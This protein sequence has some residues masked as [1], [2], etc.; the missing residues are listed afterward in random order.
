MKVKIPKYTIFFSLLFLVSA[1]KLTLINKGAYTFDDEMRYLTSG[2]I[3]KQSAQ[4]NFQKSIELIF[5][6]QGRPGDAIV[7]I[8]PNILQYVTSVIFE[9]RQFES[10]NSF[11]LFI[12]NNIVFTLILIIHYRFSLLFLKNKSLSVFSVFLLAALVASYI[13]LRHADPY[14]LSLLI[15]YYIF[16]KVLSKK[17]FNI[18][19]LKDFFYYGVIAF[20]GYCCYPGYIMLFLAIPLSYILVNLNYSNYILIIKQLTSFTIGSLF[21]LLF[22]ELLAQSVNKSYIEESIV[23]SKTILQGS[24]EESFTF[25]FKYLIEVE[26]VT[27]VFVII[28]LGLFTIQL[29]MTFVNSKKL[30]EIQKVFITLFLIFIT[31]ST[32][33]FYF[34]KVVWYGRLLK[35]FIPFLILFTVF[36]LQSFFS[37]YN[38]KNHYKTI[39][40]YSFS[41]LFLINFFNTILEYKM[42]YYPKD[43]IW[44]L[45]NSNE[46]VQ[47]HFINEYKQKSNNLFP[48]KLFSKGDSLISKKYICTIGSISPFD[49][50]NDFH[51]YKSNKTEK[52]VFS[53]PSFCNFKAYQYEGLGI[54]GR[55]N[56]DKLT[57]YVKVFEKE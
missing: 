20:F 52:L 23:L 56:L 42:Y 9:Y 3:L 50:L 34:H 37:F 12:F 33:G 46:N 1:F 19:Y 54:K 57:I 8:I 15:L 53:K 31:Y 45:Y 18:P 16:Y 25:I 2:E 39:I 5:T 51:P 13:S 11:P 22:F 44:K 36:S 35:Q 38:T 7:K 47:F 14:D 41:I 6:V 4:F 55:T 40:C 49:N 24:F 27:G 17:D 48:E 26:G 10:R 30:N 29:I 43:L 28:G 21:C 32:L